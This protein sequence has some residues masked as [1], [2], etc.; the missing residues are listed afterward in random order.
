M[1]GARTRAIFVLLSHRVE[2]MN[3]TKKRIIADHMS[4]DEVK[5]KMQMT[6]GFLK[7]QK[8]L[9][10]YNAIVDPRPVPEIARHTGLSEASVYKIIAEY[11]QKGPEAIE[12]VKARMSRSWFETD[13]NSAS[14]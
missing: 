6:A 2:E 8:W 11:N 10:V 13:A 3:M 5:M 4:V 12:Q 9:V 14:I 7:M 1:D